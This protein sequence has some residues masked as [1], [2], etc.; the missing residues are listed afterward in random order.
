[1]FGFVEKKKNVMFFIDLWHYF[2][3]SSLSHG[4]S[5]VARIAVRK[6]VNL[7]QPQGLNLISLVSS[8]FSAPAMFLFL[9][10]VL[11]VLLSLPLQVLLCFYI[12]P[13]IVATADNLPYKLIAQRFH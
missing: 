11:P 12:L 9:V 6:R 10:I 2:S 5:N 13:T 4:R 3:K 1:M 8:S 7:N